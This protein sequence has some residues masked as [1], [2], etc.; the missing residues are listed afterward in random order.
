MIKDV[1]KRRVPGIFEFYMRGYLNMKKYAVIFT[2]AAV[3]LLT[4]CRDSGPSKLELARSEGIEYMDQMQYDQAIPSFDQAF[5]LCDEKMPQTKTDI[6]LYKAACQLKLED[7]TSLKDTCT[8][9]L[10]LGENSDAYYLRGISFLKL[11]E[12][13]AAK[14]DF[15]CASDL[16]PKDYGMFLNIYRQYEEVNQSAVGDVYLQKALNIPEEDTED[17]YQKGCIYYYL[18][19]YTKAQ[20]YLA[21]PVE[22]GHQAAAE[23]MGQVYLALGDA[24][25]ARNLYQ[26]SLEKFGETPLLYNGLVLCDLAEGAYDA[27]LANA[28]TGLALEGE[29]GKRDLRYN[30]IVAYE[31]KLDFAAAKEKATEFMELYPDDEAG[32]KEYDFLIT[33]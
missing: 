12:M 5:S 11:S 22:A 1:R 7:Y 8:Q 15:D 29:D 4:G 13:D 16:A 10:S 20:E 28:E 19:D 18:Q 30:V 24:V 31:K 17:Y 2:L 6:L 33:R 27:A 32:K 9:I 14:A 21:G 23:L 25:H 26:Q 3:L